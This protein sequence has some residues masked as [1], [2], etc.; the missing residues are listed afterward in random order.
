MSISVHTPGIIFSNIM[1]NDPVFFQDHYW[2]VKKLPAEFVS[3]ASSPLCPVQAIAHRTL[4]L[5]GTQFH[6]EKYDAQH[7][8]GRQVI[9]NFFAHIDVGMRSPFI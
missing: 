5:F 6:P 1:G 7:P 9:A 2:E 4:P 8:D 3:L